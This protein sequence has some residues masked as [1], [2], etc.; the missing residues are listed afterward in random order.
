MAFRFAIQIINNVSGTGLVDLAFQEI[1]FHQNDLQLN[2]KNTGTLWFES[3]LK[4]DIFNDSAELVNSYLVEKMRIY[5]GLDRRITVPLQNLNSSNYYAII[6]VDCG[7]NNIFG[8][9]TSFTII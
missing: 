5:P 4:V 3:T 7:D 9:Q 8:N 2:L 1:T 6:I